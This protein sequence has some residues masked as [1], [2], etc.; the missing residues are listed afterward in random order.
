MY[1]SIPISGRS[2]TA[3]AIKTPRQSMVVPGR[4]KAQTTRPIAV[5]MIPLMDPAV[6]LSL[7]HTGRA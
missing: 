7:S 5:A 3:M 6:R 4:K 1:L 2:M